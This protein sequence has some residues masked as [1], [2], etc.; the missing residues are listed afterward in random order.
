MWFT[1]NAHADF[2]DGEA[3]RNEEPDVEWSHEDARE[4]SKRAEQDMLRV[5][6]KSVQ[7]LQGEEASW[8]DSL[9]APWFLASSPVV[10]CFVSL[11]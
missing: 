10:T 1:G 4:A 8:L 3:A 2:S 5:G 6:N 11:C 9:S 7:S